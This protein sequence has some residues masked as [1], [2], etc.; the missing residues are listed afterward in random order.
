MATQQPTSTPK[1][2]P[3]PKRPGGGGGWFLLF[4]AVVGVGAAFVLAPEKVREIF[5]KFQTPREG[6][7]PTTAQSAK[8]DLNER[9]AANIVNL[10][11]PS[12]V[13]RSLPNAPKA[14]KPP[15]TVKAP[16][17]KITDYA[18]DKEAQAYLRAAEQSYK[19]FDWAKARSGAQKVLPLDVKPLQAYFA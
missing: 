9:P 3:A 12:K 19:K 15:T 2:R 16:I 4:I 14:I 13:D 6:S 10:G 11:E 8:T 18:G 1:R 17:Q 7:A 5:G